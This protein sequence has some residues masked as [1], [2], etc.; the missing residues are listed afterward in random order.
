M[1][2][3]D[4]SKS[5]LRKMS[6]TAVAWMDR[7]INLPG[8][9]VAAGSEVADDDVHVHPYLVSTAV[10][11]GL[12][13]AIDHLHAFYGLLW[14]SGFLHSNAPSSLLRGALEAASSVV[15][16][17]ESD[18]RADRVHRA[19]RWYSKD[20]SDGKSAM[21]GGGPAGVFEQR[22]V[23]LQEIAVAHGL[24]PRS[25]RDGFSSTTAVTATRDFVGIEIMDVLLAWRLC[26]GYAHGRLWSQLGYADTTATP[27]AGTPGMSLVAF[28]PGYDR[29]LPLAVAAHQ[30]TSAAITLFDQRAR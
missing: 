7:K 14:C 12:H 20:A 21:S 2:N 18:D 23:K 6:D 26:S 25:V 19:L 11:V 15:W 24:D 13:A 4:E 16:L 30:S 28:T 27:I 17:L 1:L 8:F 22:K 10:S 3:E 29:L 5:Q 9:E